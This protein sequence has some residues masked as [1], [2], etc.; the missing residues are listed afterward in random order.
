[1]EIYGRLA[2]MEDEKGLEDLISEVI[3]RF[4]TPSAPAEKLFRISKIR[5]KARHLGIGSI[6]DAGDSF[7]VTWADESFMHGWNPNSLP[8]AWLP[9]LKFLPGNPTK[10][11]IRKEITKG[12]M[13]E[14]IESFI[15]AL[16]DGIRK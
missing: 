5:V 15:D 4:G 11:R 16:S 14:W 12:S 2:A 10:I 6:L 3:D 1:M 13:M 7:L 8:K 9:Y